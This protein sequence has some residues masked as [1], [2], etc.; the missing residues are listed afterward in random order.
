MS[1]VTY[2]GKT[3]ALPNYQD[4]AISFNEVYQNLSQWHESVKPDFDET[5]G[6]IGSTI[7]DIRSATKQ[8]E[9]NAKRLN[10]DEMKKFEQQSALFQR[11][12]QKFQETQIHSHVLLDSV[13]KGIHFLDRPP[14]QPVDVETLKHLSPEIQRQVEKLQ[15]TCKKYLQELVKIQKSVE[16]TCSHFDKRIGDLSRPLDYHLTV[17]KSKGSVGY[18]SW[19]LKT[20]SHW[21]VNPTIKV[22]GAIAGGCALTKEFD[23]IK[24]QEAT[25]AGKATFSP[26][27]ALQ[28]LDSSV[29]NAEGIKKKEELNSSPVAGNLTRRQ[30]KAL[31]RAQFQ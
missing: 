11:F 13:N 18:A 8:L 21:F 28:A 7:D 10:E 15:E 17:V 4:P 24:S 29:E 9:A 27:D 19:G 1:L 20:V 5:V 26:Q 14:I 23:E 22:E 30:R 25:V 12:F 16:A 6:E 3:F 31:H 2:Y